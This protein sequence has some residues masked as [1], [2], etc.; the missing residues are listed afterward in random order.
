MKKISILL[1]LLMAL[2]SGYLFARPPEFPGPFHRLGT[3]NLIGHWEGTGDFI[4]TDV[5]GTRTVEAEVLLDISKQDG[6]KFTGTITARYRLQFDPINYFYIGISEMPM[7]GHIQLD[8]ASAKRLVN[9]VSGFGTNVDE[10]GFCNYVVEIDG[11][12]EAK[13]LLPQV[14][15]TC[16]W[17]GMKFTDLGHEGCRGTPSIGEFTVTLQ[18]RPIPVPD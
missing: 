17:R 18:P 5:D 12:Y 15:L 16:R 3:P 13:A 1:V 6:N 9:M 11:Q 14:T 4:I 8:P 2:P 10:V 7:G